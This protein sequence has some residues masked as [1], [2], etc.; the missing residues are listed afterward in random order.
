MTDFER[1]NAYLEYTKKSISDFAICGNVNENSLRLY[2]KGKRKPKIDFAESILNG[3]PELNANWWLKGKGSM[4]M[5]PEVGKDDVVIKR[6][7]LDELNKNLK[8]Y[9]QS[10]YEA[11]EAERDALKKINELTE[12]NGRLKEE[13]NRMK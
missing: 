6:K 8:K 1:L 4:L 12:E 11:V 5:G 3:F 9:F 13:I 7:E 10:A 2:L